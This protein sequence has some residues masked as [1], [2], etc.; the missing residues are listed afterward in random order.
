[1]A[2]LVPQSPEHP[3][4]IRIHSNFSLQCTTDS[5]QSKKWLSLNIQNKWWNEL[6]WHQQK[7]NSAFDSAHLFEHWRRH[8]L[9]CQRITGT[10]SEYKACRELLWMFQSQESMVIFRKEQTSS[11]FSIKNVS[12]PSLTMV[13]KE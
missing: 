13:T 11:M 3:D 4:D 8:I 5:S 12:I 2:N 7:V 1:M 9:K 10:V 6:D